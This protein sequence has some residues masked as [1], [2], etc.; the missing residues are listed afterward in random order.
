MNF[1]DT[2][3]KLTRSIEVRTINISGK[4]VHDVVGGSM[5]TSR[6]LP[7]DR[8]FAEKPDP[9]HLSGKLTH[10][11]LTALLAEPA[12]VDSSVLAEKYALP[13]DIVRSFRRYCGAPTGDIEV[14]ES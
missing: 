10:Q 5:K 12:S 8:N 1:Q 2:L 3:N 4:Q 6:P 14:E 9:S 11:G 13:E 7:T